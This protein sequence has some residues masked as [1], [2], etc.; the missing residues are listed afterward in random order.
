MEEDGFRIVITPGQLAAVLAGGTVEIGLGG[1]SGWT[2]A[3][4]GAKLVFGALEELGAAA[5][6]LAPEPTTITKW[7]GGALGVHGADT[8]QSGGRQVWTGRETSTLT[9]EGTSALAHALGVDESTAREIGEG[10]DMAVPVALTLG[11]GAARLAAV[12][13]GRIILAEH[14]VAAGA[15]IGGHTI[16]THVAQSDAQL[17]T[18]LATTKLAAVSTFE[19]IDE[20]E[21][22]VTAVFRANRRAILAWART[23]AP[24]ARKPFYGAALKGGVGRVLVRGANAPVLGRTVR[25]VIKKEAYN[26]KLYYVLTAFP[27]P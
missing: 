12:R 16:L 4:G 17:A 2:R 11:V 8:L 25:V 10:V 3:W 18:R 24:K 22:A 20:A 27:V 14:E 6:V 19:T 1:A 9:S 23:A 15:E 7:A 26:G 5:L 21:R 13:G